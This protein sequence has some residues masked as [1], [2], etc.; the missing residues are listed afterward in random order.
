MTR[1]TNG[2]RD[3]LMK[4]P[5][6]ASTSPKKNRNLLIII[7]RVVVVVPLLVDTSVKPSFTQI[8]KHVA[9]FSIY[10]K[11]VYRVKRNYD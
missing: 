8:L 10:H 9:L 2:H 1:R 7:D 6:R 11:P 5:F 4:Y 3:L